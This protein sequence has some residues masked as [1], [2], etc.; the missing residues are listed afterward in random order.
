MMMKSFRKDIS[1]L[2][3]ALPSTVIAVLGGLGI[4]LAASASGL[5]WAVGKA[6]ADEYLGFL[7]PVSLFLWQGGTVFLA[8]S[9]LLFLGAAVVYVRTPD[10]VKMAAQVRKAILSYEY[11]NPL[12]LQEGQRMPRVKC[13]DMG[14]GVYEISISAVSCTIE[15]LEKVSTSISS[16]LSRK[17]SQ[18][19][20]T[21]TDADV[22]YNEIRFLLTDVTIDRALKVHSPE[23]LKQ[24]DVTRLI[25]QDG[26]CIDLR[27]SGSMLVAGK[28]R[29][30]KTTGIIALLIQAAQA[31]RDGHGSELMVIDP[32]QAELS[33]LPHTYTLDKNGEARGILEAMKQYAERIAIRQQYL[34]Q[35]SEQKGDAV[36]WWDAG[37]HPSFLFIDE[38]V[39]LR[40]LFP[41]RSSKEAPEYSLDEFDGLLRRIVTMGASAGCF[42]IISV[43]EAS[44]Q[45]GG[46]PAMIRSA[47]STKILF[48]PTLPEGRLMWDSEKL[49]DFPSRVYGPGDAW[50]SSTDGV[51]D[52]VSYVHF[53]VMQFAVYRALGELLEEYYRK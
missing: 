17:Y 50:F 33:R 23:E 49:K 40:S 28:T 46:L 36:K 44:V 27:T 6:A 22:A 31:G 34:N 16:A 14:A 53:P 25:V 19:A 52:N 4:L 48:R 42:A 29:S 39:A 9:V 7:T 35:L 47:C 12:G 30:G 38:Y 51:H 41:K 26:A 32:K 11:G 18:Y 37:M 10:R 3:F 45:E 5:G 15:Q 8:G 24:T 43:A 2:C 21:Q 13:K 20:V 1:P